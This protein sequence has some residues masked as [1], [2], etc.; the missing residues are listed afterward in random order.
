MLISLAKAL[1]GAASEVDRA[2]VMLQQE[3]RTGQEWDEAESELRRALRS[4]EDNLTEA[5][6]GLRLFRAADQCDA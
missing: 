4:I 2:Q 6:I 5:S 3:R 1:E